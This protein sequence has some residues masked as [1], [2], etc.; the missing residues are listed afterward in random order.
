[1]P[2]CMSSTCKLMIFE[3][4]QVKKV[5]QEVFFILYTLL[6]IILYYSTRLAE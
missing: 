6:H 3:R 2:S 4:G 1:M 5:K